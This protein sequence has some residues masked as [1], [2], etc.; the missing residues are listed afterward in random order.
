MTELYIHRK[1]NAYRRILII[2]PISILLIFR[3]LYFINDS[4]N[5]FKGILEAV[6]GLLGILCAIFFINAILQTKKKTPALIISQEGITD[7][8][9]LSKSGHIKWENI[10]S[11]EIK[12]F[13]GSPHLFLFLKDFSEV[14]AKQWGF[15]RLM[16]DTLVKDMGTPITINLAL[17]DFDSL[18]L[19]KLIDSKID[20]RKIELT[21]LK[22]NNCA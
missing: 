22:E 17:I 8:I 15:K 4:T 1:N 2:A 18:D 5:E 20:E 16:I 3:A 11:C 10:D 14:I 9:S 12:S 6:L 13:T 7:N 21:D 19:K